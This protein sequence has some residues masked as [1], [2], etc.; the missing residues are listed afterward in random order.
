MTLDVRSNVLVYFYINTWSLLCS[1]RLQGREAICSPPIPLN[2]P[3]VIVTMDYKLIICEQ[4]CL[5]G[6]LYTH[7]IFQL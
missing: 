3:L 6:I 5:E 1:L 2:L 7:L 4:I